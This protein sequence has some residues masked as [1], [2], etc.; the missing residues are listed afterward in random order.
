MKMFTWKI[1]EIDKYLK[2]DSLFVQTL[3]QNEQGFQKYLTADSPLW[4]VYALATRDTAKLEKLNLLRIE[5]KI[6]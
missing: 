5:N 1:D 6:L 3:R 4:I 2:T